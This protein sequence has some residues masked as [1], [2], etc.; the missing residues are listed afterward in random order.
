MDVSWT[1]RKAECRRI[2]AFKLWCLRRLL[3]IPWTARRSKP[4]NPEGNQS[5]IFIGRTDAEGEAP[6][7]WPPDVKRQKFEGKSRSGATEDELV[8]WYHWLHGH[9]LSKLQEIMKDSGAWHVIVPGVT[10]SQTWLSNWTTSIIKY[11]QM[12]ALMSLVPY[13]VPFPYVFLFI[14]PTGLHVFFSCCS[15]VDSFNLE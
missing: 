1:I 13:N 11:N 5:W 8:R 7:L 3:R 15:S 10:K 12:S 2:D 6:I 14:H 4:V 9:K